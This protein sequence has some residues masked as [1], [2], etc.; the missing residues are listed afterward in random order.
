MIFTTASGKTDDAMEEIMA[1]I[2][3]EITGIVNRETTQV[4]D[5]AFNSEDSKKENNELLLLEL[6]DMTPEHMLSKHGVNQVLLPAP[7]DFEMAA[8]FA[9]A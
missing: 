3:T 1:R 2:D 6:L 9:A 5:K 4:S 7:N 8:D